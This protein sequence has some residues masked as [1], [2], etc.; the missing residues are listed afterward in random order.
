MASSS[1]NPYAL[2]ENLVDNSEF[3]ITTIEKLRN[4]TKSQIGQLSRLAFANHATPHSVFF[5][6]G[7]ETTR[8]LPKFIAGL[9]KI[10]TDPKHLFL[11][12]IKLG[13]VP[14]I[15]EGCDLHTGLNNAAYH[16]NL[17]ALEFYLRI[18]S[19]INQKRMNELLELSACGGQMNTFKFL[20]SRG[21]SWEYISN[22]HLAAVVGGNVEILQ[23]LPPINPDD[24][25]T[26]LDSAV[27]NGKMAMFEYLLRQIPDAESIDLEDL[28]LAAAAP[29]H[30]EFFQLLIDRVTDEEI[31]E[32]CLHLAISSKSYQVIEFLHQ[33]GIRLNDQSK[34]DFD[35]EADKGFAHYL[36]FENLP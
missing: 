13:R 12:L 35:K 6:F 22:I 33:R 29:D 1:F 3:S 20:V 4:L 30:V 2:L 11:L 10:K 19:G 9:Q 28:L 7:V 25:E 26:Y 8:T 17:E 15:F 18:A 24:V 23:L 36:S 32:R 27:M 34:E 31:L 5:K 14:E 16:G 21:A